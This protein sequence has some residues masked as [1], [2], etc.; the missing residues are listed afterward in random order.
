MM[1]WL[2]QCKIREEP[3]HHKKELHKVSLFALN[4]LE[5]TVS[6]SRDIIMDSIL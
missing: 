2:L 5:G 6:D 1:A 3:I 4:H